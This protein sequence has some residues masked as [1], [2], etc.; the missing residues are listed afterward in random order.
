MSAADN[1]IENAAPTAPTMPDRIVSVNDYGAGAGGGWRKLVIG[2][3]VVAIAVVGTVYSA[4]QYFAQSRAR[5]AKMAQ[6]DARARTESP[7]LPRRQLGTAAEAVGTTSPASAST[8]TIMGTACDDKSPPQIMHERDGT[9]MLAPNGQ[10]VRVC[11]NGQVL[12]PPLAPPEARA[13]ASAPPG[14]APASTPPR[15]AAS[16]YDGD[17][18][19]PAPGQGAIAA[20]PAGTDL[21]AASL[22]Q[23]PGSA[24]EGGGDPLPAHP[25]G[26]L[27]AMLRTVP[28][29]AAQ[30]SLLANRDLILPEGRTIDCN[31][32]LRII[33]DISGKAVCVLSA[34]VYGD[35]GA[36]VLAESGSV[37]TGDYLALSASGQRRLFI[38]WARLKTPQGVVID[39]ASP[40]SDA[41]GTSG[42]D[43][44]LDNRWGE[45]IGA[46]VLLAMVDDAIGYETARASSGSGNGAAGVAVFQQTTQAGKQLAERILDSTINIKPT[47]YKQQG[48]RA[49]ITVAR[50]LDFG[51]VYALHVK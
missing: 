4:R 16:R 41:L 21:A 6:E 42:L 31:L 10:P 40:A 34:P 11:A 27:R 35:T 7:P 47:L 44:Y 25:H 15:S 9:P 1:R 51:A 32:S 5:D 20:Q 48:D 37:V 23:P 39:I 24:A 46:S 50:D 12:I 28:N 17:L 18:V 36:V 43:G 30:A 19:L 38:A 49:S 2:I 33:S 22:A 8:N 13:A 29:K 45:R 3:V 26:P 14:A